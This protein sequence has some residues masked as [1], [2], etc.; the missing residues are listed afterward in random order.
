MCPRRA[1]AEAPARC[2]VAVVGGGPAGL[3]AAEVLR[4]A[5]ADVDL[6][7][8]K[9]SVGR[10]FLIAG[11]GGLNLTHSDPPALFAGRYGARA[12]EVGGWLS[13]FDADALRAWARGLVVET[14]V[15][16]SGACSVRPQA[17]PLLLGCVQGPAH[18]RRAFHVQPSLVLLGRGGALRFEHPTARARSKRRHG[19]AL[20]AASGRSSLGR[21]LAGRVACGGRGP[22]TLRRPTAASTSACRRISARPCRSAPE[23]LVLHC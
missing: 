9:G 7:E 10:K 5:G 22:G 3:M 2:R 17:A 18:A 23:A 12:G 1:A 13:A 14:F 6:F 16:S 21:R 20:V 11:K 8:A 4:A 15:G 19:A